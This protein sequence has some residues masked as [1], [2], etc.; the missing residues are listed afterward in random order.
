MQLRTFDFDSDYPEVCSWWESMGQTPVDR[1]MFTDL[2][3]VAYGDFGT[4]AVAWFY[5]DN[6]SKVARVEY[7]VTN[8]DFTDEERREGIDLI[9][10]FFEQQARQIGKRIEVIAP[11]FGLNV[12]IL[13]MN[14]GHELLDY[15]EAQIQKLPEHEM[16]TTHRFTPGMYIR[17]IFIPFGTLLT[18]KIHRTEHPFVISKGDISVWTRETGAVRYRAP[19]SGITKP[20]T[21]RLLFAH[22][23]TIWTTFHATTE[24][25]VDKIESQIIEPHLNLMLLKEVA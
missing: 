16:V 24:T 18:S 6:R 23:D 8:P 3:A 19:H 2:G 9:N 20:G 1:C 13:P 14:E 11:D 15:C 10:G 17:Q 7:A 22:E 21:R 25:D 4:V 12:A 5:V